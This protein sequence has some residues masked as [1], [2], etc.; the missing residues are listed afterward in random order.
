VFVEGV[1]RE[2]GNTG[3]FVWRI[4]FDNKRC[5]SFI[6]TIFLQYFLLTSILFSEECHRQVFSG[7]RLRKGG[8]E[9]LRSRGRLYNIVRRL[10]N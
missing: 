4:H 6:R 3:D 10:R 2:R 5:E 7:Y 1:E 9:E 8:L